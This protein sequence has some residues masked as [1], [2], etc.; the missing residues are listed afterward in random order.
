MK[1]CRVG[2]LSWFAGVWWLLIAL[3]LQSLS[4]AAFYAR[5]NRAAWVLIR[6]TCRAQRAALACAIEGGGEL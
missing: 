1:E 2:S 3:A 5:L 4:W 6:L